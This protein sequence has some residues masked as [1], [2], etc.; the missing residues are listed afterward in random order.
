MT[1]SNLSFIGLIIVF[2]FLCVNIYI[3]TKQGIT[4]MDINLI[5]F[6]RVLA[7]E[8]SSAK[9]N[10]LIGVYSKTLEKEFR[11]RNN[12]GFKASKQQRR[13]RNDNILKLVSDLRN[14]RKLVE[15]RKHGIKYPQ[16]RA[17]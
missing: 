1:I 8:I 16:I 12:F 10:E 9:P 7:D 11:N 6:F 13:Y 14:L 15:L 2:S 5:R 17:L 4:K 3:L